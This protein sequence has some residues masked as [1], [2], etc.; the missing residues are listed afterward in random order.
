MLDPEKKLND[1]Q[2]AQMERIFDMIEHND[3]RPRM[4]SVDCDL[5][6][7]FHSECNGCASDLPCH[8]ASSILAVLSF[9]QAFGI[10][11][12]NSGELFALLNG[13]NKLVREI[14]N[15][16]TIDEVDNVMIH[17][18]ERKQ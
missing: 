1:T 17:G 16:K 5:W 8:K 4:F 2:M 9:T 13:Q 6:R 10:F 7:L 12:P 11:A 18:F 15:S 3:A 14:C